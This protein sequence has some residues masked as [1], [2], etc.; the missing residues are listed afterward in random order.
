VSNL[1]NA[2][3]GLPLIFVNVGCGNGYDFDE[4]LIVLRVF[5]EPGRGLRAYWTAKVDGV[6]AILS[7]RRWYADGG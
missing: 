5:G 1:I 7:F 3:L 2:A 4:S 6:L